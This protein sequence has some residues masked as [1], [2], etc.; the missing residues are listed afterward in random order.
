[1]LGRLQVKIH[2]HE[3]FLKLHT[4][5]AKEAAKDFAADD[6]R[7][8][9]EEDSIFEQALSVYPEGEKTSRPLSSHDKRKV[10]P[11]HHSLPVDAR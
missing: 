7:W 2:A 3:Y 1:V 6:A 9:F 5:C 4:F 11:A 10:R 8:S